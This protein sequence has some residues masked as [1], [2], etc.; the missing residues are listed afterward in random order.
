MTFRLRKPEKKNVVAA[1]AVAAVLLIAGAWQALIACRQ[2]WFVDDTRYA[3]EINRV[4][5]RCGVPPQLVRAVVFQ[6]SKF[7]ADARGASG[8]IGLM[9]V[10][11][12]GAVADWAAVHQRK[13]PSGKELEDP[14]LNLTIGVWYLARALERWKDYHA[15]IELALIQYNAGE[16]RAQRWAPEDKNAEVFS[17]IKIASTRIYVKNIMTRY[18]KYLTEQ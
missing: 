12:R 10:M 4:S 3:D 6:E 5:V 8:E 18:R 1:I 11:P 9:Q 16:K 17:R 15:Q 13:V 2:G 14:E 7:E